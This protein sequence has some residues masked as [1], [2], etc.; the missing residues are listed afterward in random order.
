MA[1]DFSIEYVKWNSIPRVDAQSK[2]RFYK[3]PKDKT[4]E[5]F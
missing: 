1:F 5:K 2:L 4:K 3:E